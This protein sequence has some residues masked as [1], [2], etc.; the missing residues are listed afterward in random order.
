MKVEIVEGESKYSSI[1][2]VKGGWVVF[3]K[4]GFQSKA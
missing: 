4:I 2:C 1:K 3:N